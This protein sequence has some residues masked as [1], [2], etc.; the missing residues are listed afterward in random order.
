MC[1]RSFCERSVRSD[2][3]NVTRSRPRRDFG[4]LS[5]SHTLMWPR[6]LSN[7]DRVTLCMPRRRPE[8]TRPTPSKRRLQG[9]PQTKPTFARGNANSDPKP[10]QDARDRFVICQRQIRQDDWPLTAPRH[11]IDGS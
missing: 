3:L 4:Y 9:R 2:M 10:Q 5:I 7:G 8:A 1:L 11:T 6:S